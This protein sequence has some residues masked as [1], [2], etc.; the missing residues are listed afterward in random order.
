MM[1]ETVSTLRRTLEHAE[2]FIGST[3]TR[4][5]AATA[6]Y[7]EL[8]SRLGGELNRDP[9]EPS[10][11]IDNLV[12][13][14]KDGLL[15]SGT[16][17][18][19]AWVISGALPS[20][21]AADW[22]TS[23]WDQN[24]VTYECSPSAAVVEEVVGEW[25]KD[26]LGLPAEASF[27]LTTGCQAAHFT[28]LAAA[29]HAVLE[30]S[31]WDLG[32]RGL[33]GAPEIQVLVS[34]LRHH[35]IDRALRFLGF[36][37]RQVV[38]LPVDDFGQIKVQSLQCALAQTGGPSVLVLSAGE[39][40]T[41]EF[42]Q[43][44]DLIP[45]AR[46]SGAWVHVDGAFGLIARASRS[47]R[48]YLDGVELADSWATDAHKWLNVPFDCG[49]VFVRDSAAHLAAMTINAEYIQPT[50]GARDQIDW[51]PE[52]SRRGRGFAVY[53]A[54]REL[55]RQGVENLVDRCCDHAAALVEGIGSLPGV[56]IIHRPSLNQG[57]VRF[58]DPRAGADEAA[59]DART[60]QVISAINA[61]G[62][63]F[64]SGTIWQ[65]RKA[66]RVSVVNWRTTDE[67]VDRVIRA[68]ASVLG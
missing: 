34:E 54:L 66:M 1:D 31:G 45:M 38:R 27:A 6:T 22:L 18:F 46:E 8:R 11:V 7:D 42:D 64:F 9:M 63:A 65:Q 10:Q 41:G 56:R 37:E 14:T 23:T 67:D 20:A 30:R 5:V 50:A 32:A 2:A 13:A 33:F 25:L 47:K 49:A 60:D 51:T 19:Y 16:G 29:R 48:A 57:L 53:A 15:G 39:I 59:H 44:S 24:A 12:E 26:L 4:R 36:G 28:G 61:T 55:G 43:F 52:W 21:L 68:C 35:S 3:D 40:N 62:E 17:R 58:L